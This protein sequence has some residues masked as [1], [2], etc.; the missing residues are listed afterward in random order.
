VAGRSELTIVVIEHPSL[1]KV[2][3][4]A[5]SAIWNDALTFDE[6]HERFVTMRKKTA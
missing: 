3:K 2:L 4:I 5:F 1:A 6:A